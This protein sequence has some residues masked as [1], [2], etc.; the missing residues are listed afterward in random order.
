MIFSDFGGHGTIFGEPGVHCEEFCDCCDFWGTPA[1]K[2]SSHF[3]TRLSECEILCGVV[4][5]CFF[6]VFVVLIFHYFGCPGAPFWYQ[7]LSSFESPGP[8]IFFSNCVTVIKFKG[9]AV[10]PYSL[11]E[12][13]DGACVL[14]VSF[15]DLCDF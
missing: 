13:L 1:A 8:L 14:I 10:S 7:F 9:L 12:S 6:R 3:E 5:C 2:N 15:S 4:S 11:F